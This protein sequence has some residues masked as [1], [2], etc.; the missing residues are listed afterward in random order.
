MEDEPTNFTKQMMMKRPP[1][2]D[3][4]PMDTF[5]VESRLYC[6][7]EKVATIESGEERRAV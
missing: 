6:S 5:R 7:S 1:K 2:K 3:I 4:T